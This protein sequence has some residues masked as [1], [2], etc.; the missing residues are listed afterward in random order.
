[1]QNEDQKILI[2]MM[3]Q[4]A[5]GEK[6]DIQLNSNLRQ[7]LV[8]AISQQS[9]MN[10]PAIKQESASFLYLLRDPQSRCEPGPGC[11]DK[12]TFSHTSPA[13][14]IGVHEGSVGHLLEQN[15]FG[16]EDVVKRRE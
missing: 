16:G 2:M 13:S 3:R 6:T 9:H 14:P 11:K 8:A 4:V 15:W 12:D 5:T 7:R 10:Q 1:M